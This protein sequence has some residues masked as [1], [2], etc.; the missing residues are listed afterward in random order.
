MISGMLKFVGIIFVCAIPG[1]TGFF[2]LQTT[3][4]NPDDTNY[5]TF[6]TLIIV[7][8]SMLIGSIFFS[9]LSEALNCVFIFYCLDT[10]L[11]EMGYPTAANVP[12]SMRNVLD[13]MRNS[14]SGYSQPQ[15]YSQPNQFYNQ[16]NNR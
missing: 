10:K 12:P 3:A 5:L 8:I 7:L 1:I 11:A 16:P 15:A 2:L 13:D 9:A 14:H 4:E 6:G